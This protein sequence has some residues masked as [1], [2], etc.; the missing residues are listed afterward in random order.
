MSLMLSK[1]YSPPIFGGRVLVLHTFQMLCPGCVSLALPQAQ[2]VHTMFAQDEVAVVG[3]HTVFEHHTAMQPHA[4]KA[5]IHEYRLTFPF[6][7]D[8]HEQ[9]ATIPNTMEAYQLRGT[10]GTVLIDKQGYLRLAHFG[11]VDS[12]ELGKMIGLLLGERPDV[13]SGSENQGAVCTPEGCD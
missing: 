13:L 1:R 3:L 8:R 7:V 2:K 5:F 6:G 11:Q 12:L 9:G 10:P 4:L